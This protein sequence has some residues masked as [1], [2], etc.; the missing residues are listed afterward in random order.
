MQTK[1]HR[2]NRNEVLL[3]NKIDNEFNRMLLPLNILQQ[4]TFAKKY[5]IR[6][7]FITSNDTI[8]NLVP[9]FVLIFIILINTYQCLITKPN[10]L[11]SNMLQIVNQIVWL[12]FEPVC[13][14]INFAYTVRYSNIHV[15]LLLKLQRLA[16]F[17][18]YSKYKY[19]SI[20]NW[21]QAVGLVFYHVIMIL[22]LYFMYSSVIW[23]VVF[24]LLIN[25]YIYYT[26][27]YVNL[28]K[29]NLVL[30]T[31]NIKQL[32]ETISTKTEEE[33]DNIHQT[34]SCVQLFNYFK[35]IME[36]FCIVK[37]MFEL[38]VR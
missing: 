5:I 8:T 14:L 4:I 28:L 30:W 2:R 38:L 15:T 19:F 29:K 10:R 12:V 32:E 6:D 13:I 34:E 25:S 9:F 27:R 35:D 24:M 36:A 21:I 18:K 37:K 7:K 1:V 3:S 11:F 23:S 33:N 17:T 16:K 31:D 20:Y 26:S 22:F